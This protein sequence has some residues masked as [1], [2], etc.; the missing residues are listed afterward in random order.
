M[1]KIYILLFTILFQFANAQSV[2]FSENIGSPTAT[3]A[4]SAN[5]FQNS[6]PILFSGTADIRISTPSDTYPG[7]SGNGCIFF[8][9]TT[10]AKTFI[11]EGINT[12]NYSDIVLSFGHQKGT[13]AGNNELTVS[14]SSDGTNWIPLSY[15]RPTGPGTSIWTLITATGTIPATSNLRI[16]FENP[17]SNIGFRVDDIKLTGTT[18]GIKENSISGLKIYPNPVT[19]G[20]VF[21]TTDANTQK[22][23]VI[24][25]VLGKQVINTTAF[26]SVNVANLKMGVYIIKITEEGKT[27]TRK[28]VIK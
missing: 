23:I 13:N 28:L 25:D 19:N 11:I 1:K 5:V 3:T 6:T 16:K 9:G 2:I 27:A 17:I 10:P 26:D 22:S 24:F 4:I 12:S 7:A 21:I 14:V 15:T 18:M 20:K 8:G